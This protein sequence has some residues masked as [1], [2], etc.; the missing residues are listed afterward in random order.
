MNYLDRFME[1]LVA[2]VFLCVGIMNIVS[3]KRRPRALGAR[4]ATLPFGLPNWAFVLVGLFEIVAATALV[5]PFG[6]FPPANVALIAASGLAFLTLAAALFHMR[7][8][9]TA[10]PSA[11]LFLL[12]LFVIVGYTV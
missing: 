8:Q 12:A 1:A 4:Q 5:V 11:V 10:V 6:P 9:E 3:Y 2:I 7:R